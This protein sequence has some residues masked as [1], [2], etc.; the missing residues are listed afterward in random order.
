MPRRTGSISTQALRSSVRCKDG[1]LAGL[2]WLGMQGL[3][4]GEAG[5]TEATEGL[6]KV[7]P[8]ASSD[9]ASPEPPLELVSSPAL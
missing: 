4:L 3:E 1:Q 2:T 5:P 7:L 9:A 8:V 6:E